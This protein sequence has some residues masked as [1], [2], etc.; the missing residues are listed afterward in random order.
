MKY[1]FVCYG[2][3]GSTYL[4]R[5]L[6]RRWRTRLRPETYWL[7][8]YF[9]QQ[10]KSATEFDQKLDERGYDNLPSPAS[11][12]GF[13]NRNGGY[14]ADPRRSIGEN[15]LAYFLWQRERDRLAV[16]F[17]RAP[18]HGF[19]TRIR[20]ALNRGEVVFVVRHP[21]HQYVSLTKPQRHFEFVEDFGGIDTDGDVRFFAEEWNRYVADAL[22]SGSAIVRYEFMRDDVGALDEIPRA[23]LSKWDAGRRNDC[24]LSAD[25]LGTLRSLVDSNYRRVYGSEWSI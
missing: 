25:N 14:A 10:K 18:M 1:A 2:G 15:M 9:P 3:S 13:Q 11:I 23:V 19:F 20:S 21:L 6:G 4:Y 12:I 22:S 5:R 17:S 8:H 24:P 16:L 7:P